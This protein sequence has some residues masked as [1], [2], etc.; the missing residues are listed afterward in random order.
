MKTMSHV[1]IFA[2]GLEIFR[3]RGKDAGIPE[4]GW[5]GS[6]NDIAKAAKTTGTDSGCS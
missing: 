2:A 4:T 3:G 5:E 6:R 1:A